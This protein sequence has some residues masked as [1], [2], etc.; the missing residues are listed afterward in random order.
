MTQ[1]AYLDTG[2][3]FMRHHPTTRATPLPSRLLHRSPAPRF[4]VFVTGGFACAILLLSLL[5]YPLLL[6]IEVRGQNLLWWL[7]VLT[8]LIVAGLQFRSTIASPPQP[9]THLATA[10][11]PTRCLWLPMILFLLIS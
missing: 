1:R 6:F 3:A 5:N 8:L 2:V 10:P 9:L 11:W 4:T 7:S